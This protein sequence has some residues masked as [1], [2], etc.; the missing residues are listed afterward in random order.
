MKVFNEVH[1]FVLGDFEENE[2][3]LSQVISG[4]YESLNHITKDHINKKTLLENFDQV[5]VIIDEMCD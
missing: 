3:I 2:I 1:L 5:I 4:L